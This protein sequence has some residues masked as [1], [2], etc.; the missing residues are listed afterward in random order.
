MYPSMEVAMDEAQVVGMLM[1]LIDGDLE[2]DEDERVGGPAM[3]GAVVQ[4]YGDAGMLTWN[5]GFV[6]VLADSAEFKITVVRA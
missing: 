3:T 5:E 2:R 1:D 4:R 6:L